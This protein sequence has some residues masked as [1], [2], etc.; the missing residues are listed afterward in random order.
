MTQ[1]VVN[2]T[3]Y[4]ANPGG[5][6]SF[7]EIDSRYI[8]VNGTRYL[9]H[10]GVNGSYQPVWLN[11][12]EYTPFPIEVSDISIPGAGNLPRPKLRGSN[13]NGYLSQ[14]L[15]TQGDLIGAKFIRRRC[16]IRFL[17]ARNWP[18]GVNPYGTPDPTAAYDD[19]TY[20]INRKVTENP[21]MVEFETT[22]SF[23]LDN[24]Q[25]PRRPIL[26]IICPFQFRDPETCGYGG[27][28]VQDTNGKSFTEAV[29][30]GGYGYT[31]N[32]RGAWA[33]GSTYQV[34]DWVTVLSQNDFTYGDTFVYV[35]SAAN[36]T[37]S[38]NNPQFNPTNW[39]QDA[40]T[41]NLFGCDAHFDSPLP[42]GGTPGVARASF[43]Q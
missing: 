4:L 39:V 29:V 13:I 38:S 17:D 9:W 18:D 12:E 8:S 7:Y 30:D 26:A 22:S 34:G 36:T 32:S 19:E 37:G 3:S 23:E 31:L 43:S 35:C 28:P 24:V 11:G 16:F 20:Y 14:F 6:L 33:S 10:A 41:N 42:F 27:A 25:L 40:C 1:L 2:A 21:E 15:L 5:L